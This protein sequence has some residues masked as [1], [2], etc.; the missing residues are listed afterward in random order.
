MLAKANNGEKDNLRAFMQLALM[1][2]LTIFT[3]IIML[4]KTSVIASSFGVSIEMDAFNFANNIGSFIYSFIG[5][6]VTTILIPNLVNKNKRESI[7]IFISVLYS[8]AFIVLI[9]VNV[10]R[11]V[12][13]RA[14]S[15]GNEQFILITC[16]IM[17]VTLITQYINSFTGATNAIFQCSGKFNF[18]K[19]ITLVTSSML[20]LL[21]VITPNITIYK[22]VNIVLI[23]TIINVIIQIYLAI[24]GGYFYKYKVDFKDVEFRKMIRIFVPTVLSTGLYQVSL[25]IDSIISA[26]LGQGEI[27]K[28]SYSNTIM[29]LINAVI[30]SNIMTYFYPKI[31]KNINKQNGQ[32]KMFDLSILINSIMILVVVG[33]VTVGRE[34]IVILYERGKFTSEITSIVY[35]CT[36]I[37]MIGLPTNAFRDLIYRYFYAKQ[38]TL[39]PF[40]NSL[41]ISFINIAISIILA[42]FIGI[43]GIILGTVITSYLSLIMILF[44]FSKK[45]KVQYSKMCLIIENS[46]LIFSAILTILIIGVFKEIIPQLNSIISLFLYGLCTIFIYGVSIYLLKSKVFKLKLND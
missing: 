32:K 31:A 5:A 13:V 33:F 29:T 40:K 37:Y 36:L 39:T 10:F 19:F 9:I 26:N 20:V 34:S 8:F 22:Y 16:N 44:R 12:L 25:L 41:I 38:D 28:L 35:K 3:Q 43:Y 18:P 15:S 1:M 2:F 11:G 23:T 46:K 21:V 27:S 7:N 4:L 24:K 17:F 14:L 42:K 45:F 6:G 30:L